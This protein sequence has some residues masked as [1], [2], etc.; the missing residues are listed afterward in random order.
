MRYG[1][2]FSKINVCFWNRVVNKGTLPLAM[3]VKVVPSSEPERMYDAGSRSG[4]SLAEVRVRPLTM[5]EPAVG[6]TVKPVLLMSKFRYLF[7]VLSIALATPSEPGLLFEVATIGSPGTVTS[8]G[9][10]TASNW[11]SDICIQL[12]H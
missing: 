11:T 2:L 4:A 12:E 3:V 6:V 1:R 5:V 8:V 10:T 9:A 7:W